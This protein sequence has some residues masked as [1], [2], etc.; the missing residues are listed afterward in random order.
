MRGGLEVSTERNEDPWHSRGIRDF[1]RDWKEFA[2]W[3]L[4]T[5]HSS[6]KHLL[7]DST[8]TDVQN[9]RQNTFYYFLIAAVTD[10]HNCD[11]KHRFSSSHPGC[12]KSKCISLSCHQGGGRAAFSSEGSREK[13][14]FL[15][16]SASRSCLLS[17]AC[18][19]TV[20]L[21]SQQWPV[22]S[23]SHHI[24]LNRQSCLPLSLLRTPVIALDPPGY[25][26][27]LFLS[28][29]QLIRKLNFIRNRKSPCHVT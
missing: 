10:Y 22:R 1:Q 5:I 2:L 29:G 25:S 21:Q 19:H 28:Q 23:F 15:L 14:I 20:H 24:T 9:G 4:D 16:F 26:R 17:L 8:G 11:L 27:I 7:C 3:R 13:S 12:Q 18:G 6:T